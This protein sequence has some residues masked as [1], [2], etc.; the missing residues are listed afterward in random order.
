MI[1]M[2]WINIEER[3]PQPNVDVLAYRNDGV[4]RITYFFKSGIIKPKSKA[5]RFRQ[6]IRNGLMITHWMPLPIPP[7]NEKLLKK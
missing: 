5:Y 3:F 6:D 7:K 2:E 4:I 1:W